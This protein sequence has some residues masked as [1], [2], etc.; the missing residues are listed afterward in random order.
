MCHASFVDIVRNADKQVIE[1]VLKFPGA[2]ELIKIDSIK[3]ERL[4]E[5]LK[6]RA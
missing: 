3:D 6:S 2:L 4:K 5:A 1:P